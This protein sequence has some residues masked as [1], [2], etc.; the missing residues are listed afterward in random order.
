MAFFEKIRL[1]DFLGCSLIEFIFITTSLF[2]SATVSLL[3]VEVELAIAANPPFALIFVS[4]NSK[5][6]I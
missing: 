3:S 4:C 6:S 5:E 1:Q 2:N